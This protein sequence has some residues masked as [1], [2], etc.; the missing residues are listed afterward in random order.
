MASGKKAQ[1]FHLAA[2]PLLSGIVSCPDP[3]DLRPA[4]ERIVGE[5]RNRIADG[6]VVVLMGEQHPSASHKALQQAVLGKL[7]DETSVAYG[8]ERPHDFLEWFVSEGFGFK[9]PPDL[10]GRIS[11]ADRN[12]CRLIAAFLAAAWPADVPVSERSVLAFCREKGISVRANDAAD[13]DLFLDQDDPATRALIEQYAPERLGTLIHSRDEALGVEL[14]NRMIV[15]RALAHMK[16][17]GAKVYVQQCGKGHIFGNN[18]TGDEFAGSLSAMFAKTGVNVLSVFPA[19][20]GWGFETIPAQ[21]KEQLHQGLIIEGLSE[22]EFHHDSPPGEE[23]A[24]L[25][26]IGRHSG[27]DIHIAQDEAPE[28]A[29]RMQDRIR[30]EIPAWISEVGPAP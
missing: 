20:S 29:A 7:R 25:R 27:L 21:A 10:R 5:V 15:E 28:E 14:R 12:S 22:R 19:G 4:V 18:M 3:L 23:E 6:P 11:D 30:R 17:S 8:V 2:T 24:F 13:A 16:E 9:I 26:E 1:S